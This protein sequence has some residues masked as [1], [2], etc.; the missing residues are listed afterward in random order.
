[1]N[2][3]ETTAIYLTDIEARQFIDFQ[4]HYTLI[5]LLESLNVFNLK[6]GSCEIHFNSLGEI[7]GINIHTHYSV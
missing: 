3:I 2:K 7:K 1:M 4:K 6:N 5:G